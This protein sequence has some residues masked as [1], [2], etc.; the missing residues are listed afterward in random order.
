MGR[1]GEGEGR[2]ARARR[3]A[4]QVE[5]QL[6]FFLAS[7]AASVTLMAVPLL[8]AWQGGAQGGEWGRRVGGCKRGGAARASPLCSPTPQPPTH[9][10]ALLRGQRLLGDDVINLGEDALEGLRDRV[11][12]MGCCTCR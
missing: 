11:G 4:A 6:V 8:G 5:Q 2:Q 7:G 1:C 3:A 10:H 12:G 9:L